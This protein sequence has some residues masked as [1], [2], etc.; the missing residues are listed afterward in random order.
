[1]YVDALSAVGLVSKVELYIVASTA[2][3][4]TFFLGGSKMLGLK[5]EV[6]EGTDQETLNEMSGK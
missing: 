1:L 5:R 6:H 4:I 2:V 3:H